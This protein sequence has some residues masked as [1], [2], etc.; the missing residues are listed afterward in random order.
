[1]LEL[2]FFT[3]LHPGIDL[4]HEVFLNDDPS[5]IGETPRNTNPRIF[6]ECNHRNTSSRM[7]TDV[8]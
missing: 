6:L 3:L 2:H 8:A 1:M 7:K 4:E 5:M